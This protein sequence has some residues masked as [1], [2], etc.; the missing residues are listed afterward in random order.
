ML[1]LVGAWLRPMRPRSPVAKPPRT[2][3]QVLPASMER[4]HDNVAAA[5]VVAD[6]DQAGGPG[7]A[8]VGGLVQAALAAALPERSGGGH[9]HHVGIARIHHDAG[10]VLG[11]LE[12]H[13]V[14]GAPAVFAL[15]D[16]VAVGDA[17][18]V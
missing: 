6:F 16:A 13:V 7:L 12:S 14:E 10:D 3:V 2:C 8:A 5:G 17:A 11:E 9:V 1:G 18:L 4:V 15:V